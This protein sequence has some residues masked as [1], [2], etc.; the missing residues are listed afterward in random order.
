MTAPAV[1]SVIVTVCA[2]VNVQIVTVCAVVNVP[3]AGEIAGVAAAS[4]LI[5]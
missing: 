4:R 5:V 1:V 2:V 3:P